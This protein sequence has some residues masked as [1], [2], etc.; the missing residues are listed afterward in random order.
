[1]GEGHFHHHLDD[2]FKFSHS[3]IID[4]EHY[5]IDLLEKKDYATSVISK[6]GNG[7]FTI[8]TFMLS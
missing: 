6:W 8:I 5:L 4:V 1:M 2:V 7:R 3:I